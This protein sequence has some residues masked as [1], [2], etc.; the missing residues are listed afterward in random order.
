M[1]KII[2]FLFVIAIFFFVPLA[3]IAQPSNRP[4]SPAGSPSGGGGPA[5]GGP[6]NPAVPVDGGLGI[7]LAAGGILGA[8][9]LYKNFKE[10][11]AIEK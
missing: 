7:L 8:K 3:T 6:S 9:R 11:D 1:H 2:K 10:Q 4:A 5:G